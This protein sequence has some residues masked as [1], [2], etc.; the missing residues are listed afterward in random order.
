MLLTLY[1]YYGL[2]TERY[3][4]YYCSLKLSDGWT[5][6]NV[7][8]GEGIK[9]PMYCDCPCIIDIP[10]DK[11]TVIRHHYRTSRSVVYEYIL[12]VEAIKYVSPKI[13]CISDG[14]IYSEGLKVD[15]VIDELTF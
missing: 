8:F 12:K 1:P 3:N 2:K 11:A 5:I 13:K 6:L 14:P 10:N 9:P 4:G 15:D 7:Q